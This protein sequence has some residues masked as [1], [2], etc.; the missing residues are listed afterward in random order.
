MSV[1]GCQLSV[2]GTAACGLAVFLQSDRTGFNPAPISPATTAAP[3]ARSTAS[4]VARRNCPPRPKHSNSGSLIPDPG[5]TPNAQTRPHKH[6][7]HARRMLGPLNAVAFVYELSKN[8]YVK[9][10]SSPFFV[11]LVPPFSF[12]FCIGRLGNSGRLTVCQNAS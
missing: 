6:A 12:G 4:K 5:L 3:A 9:L 11:F 7:H 8:C 1:V 2:V 10:D